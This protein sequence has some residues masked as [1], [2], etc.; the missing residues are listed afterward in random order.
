MNFV[1]A[2]EVTK[3]VYWKG[4]ETVTKLATDDWYSQ[5]FHLY[6]PKEDGPEKTEV[7]IRYGKDHPA[8]KKMSITALQYTMCPLSLT[9]SCYTKGARTPYRTVKMENLCTRLT[10]EPDTTRIIITCSEKH[11]VAKTIYA[12]LSINYIEF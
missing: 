2:K 9:I 7:C 6:M 4:R 10:L 11:N 1:R 12:R 3:T 5:Y 8:P